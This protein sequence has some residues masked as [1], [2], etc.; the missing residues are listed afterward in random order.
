MTEGPTTALCRYTD[1]AIYVREKNLVEDM[2]GETSFTAAMFFL[3]TGR[4]ARP[5]DIAILDSVLVVLMDHG[6]SPSAITSRLLYMS[7]PEALQAAVAGG[8]LAVGSQFV[9]TMENA[10]LLL[11][12]IAEDPAGIETAARR[13]AEDHRA[14]RERMPGFGHHLHK[15]DDP[16]PPK[17]IAVAEAQGVDGRYIAALR[18]LAGAVDEAAGRHI[19]INATGAIAAI[20][21]EIDLP[22]EILRG[23]AVISRAAGLVAHIREEQLKPGGRNLWTAGEKAVPYDAEG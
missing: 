17:L 11:K 23:F 20:L 16:R 19:T 2:V 7:A 6:L 14:R 22:P 13:I 3:I 8:L 5:A 21:L 15:P 1:D 4:E 10:A 9:G 18:A 12:E